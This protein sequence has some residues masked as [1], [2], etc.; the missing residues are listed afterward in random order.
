MRTLKASRLCNPGASGRLDTCSVHKLVIVLSVIN[1]AAPAA[2]AAPFS[3]LTHHSRAEESSIH[4]FHSTTTTFSSQG[5]SSL[6][7]KVEIINRS[8]EFK[9]AT[10]ACKTI[11]YHLLFCRQNW[12]ILNSVKKVKFFC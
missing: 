6:K 12:R 1:R 8:N 4:P 2:A 5:L 7:V 3:P 9:V 10:F 11:E